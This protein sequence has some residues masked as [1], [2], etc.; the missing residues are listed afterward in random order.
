M[1]PACWITTYLHSAAVNLD[2]SVQEENFPYINS[3]FL[4]CII[5]FGE[6]MQQKRKHALSSY[7]W[8]YTHETVV[9]KKKKKN[10]QHASVM[11]CYYVFTCVHV[12]N[13]L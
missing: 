7:A 12:A 9:A 2:S 8:C 6:D 1:N 5:L 4:L 13:H 11:T 3:V 10:R